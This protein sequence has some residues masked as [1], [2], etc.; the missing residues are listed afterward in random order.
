MV[1]E[2]LTALPGE[3]LV[4]G[5]PLHPEEWQ[6][7]ATDDEEPLLHETVD[8]A[9]LFEWLM[10]GLMVIGGAA[11]LILPRWLGRKRRHRGSRR[12]RRVHTHPR[13]AEA[14]RGG[15]RPTSHR[16]R[17]HRRRHHATVSLGDGIDRHRNT[18]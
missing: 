4:T 17:R 6:P 8:R 1:D 14:S 18:R 13:T 5:I 7:P 11:L 15:H 2:A 16:R 3:L 12:H 10:G 9:T